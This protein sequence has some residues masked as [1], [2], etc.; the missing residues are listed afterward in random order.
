MLKIHLQALGLGQLEQFQRSDFFFARH[1]YGQSIAKQSAVA[2]TLIILQDALR[3]HL[4][5]RPIIRLPGA[6][7]VATLGLA[8]R[9][10]LLPLPSVARHSLP[11]VQHAQHANQ[12]Q[13]LPVC[14]CAKLSAGRAWKHTVR[15]SCTETGSPASTE[16]QRSC[17][18][19]SAMC[20]RRQLPILASPAIVS[21]Q[22]CL[23]KTAGSGSSGPSAVHSVTFNG[24]HGQQQQQKGAL[25]HTCTR[26]MVS[27]PHIN[28]VGKVAE[29]QPIAVADNGTI[30]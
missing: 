30:D 21:R 5:V 2:K 13:N 19:C 10:S 3:V 8:V 4:E 26:G 12:Q 23:G 27:G 29:V 16:W 1:R 7:I 14:T 9:K 18:T 28:R 20:S 6:P 11:Q 22:K 25:N 24:A 17:A 15:D